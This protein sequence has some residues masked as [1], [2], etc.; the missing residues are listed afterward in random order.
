MPRP[1]IVYRIDDYTRRGMA[2][3]RKVHERVFA[4]MGATA[5]QHGEGH[6]GAGHIVGT[7]RMGSDEKASVVNADLRAHDH[8]NLFVVG[9]AVFPTG[10]TANP[11]LTIAALSLRCTRTIERTLWQ[12]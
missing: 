1:R 10:A 3:G 9:S 7:L 5:I 12:L 6:E 2:E 11:T 4:A 8:A